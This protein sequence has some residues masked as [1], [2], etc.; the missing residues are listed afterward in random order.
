MGCKDTLELAPDELRYKKWCRRVNIEQQFTLKLPNYQITM[1]KL[2][3]AAK[4]GQCLVSRITHTPLIVH[5]AT[6]T[7]QSSYCPSVY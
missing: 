6:P 4:A 5:V 7:L 1:G 2:A 3:H